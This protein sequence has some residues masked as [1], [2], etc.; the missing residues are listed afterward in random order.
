MAITR[1]RE[2]ATPPAFYGGGETFLFSIERL[3]D[4]PPLPVGTDPP[5][6]EAVHVHRWTGANSY[7]MF[8]SRDH[9]A[10]GSGGHFGLFLDADLLH[11]SS[12]PCETFSNVCLCRQRPGGVQRADDTPV[13]EYQCAVL[14]VWGMDHSNISRRQ[15]EMMM[16]G[17]RPR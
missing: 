8:S 6:N 2:P 10:M 15:H 17:L 11:G 7:F 3:H 12:G 14:E 5:P 16:R 9:L 4:L 1:W 13:G